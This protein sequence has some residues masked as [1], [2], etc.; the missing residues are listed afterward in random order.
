[1]PTERPTMNDELAGA[2]TWPVLSHNRHNGMLWCERLMRTA[3]PASSDAARFMA[4][5]VK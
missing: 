2:P 5:L 4:G 3:S 1:M